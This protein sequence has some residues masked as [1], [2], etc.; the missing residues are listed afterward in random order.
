V[1]PELIVIRSVFWY[2]LRGG[3]LFL[4]FLVDGCIILHGR[5]LPPL[6]ANPT[7]AP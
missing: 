7:S 1:G 6:L 4:F 5:I 3:F 2:R